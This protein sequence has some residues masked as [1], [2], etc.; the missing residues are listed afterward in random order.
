MQ[1]TLQLG[2][3]FGQAL[4][5]SDGGDPQCGGVNVVG[6]LRQVYRIQRVDHGVVA[7]RSAKQLAGAV[8][9]DFIDIHVGRGSGASLKRVQRK[10]VG[11]AAFR[12]FAGCLEYR[13]TDLGIE[14]A[15]M[16]VHFRRRLL[17]GGDGADQFGVDGLP[18]HREIFQCADRM[19]P[20]IGGGRDWF[21][22]EKVGFRPVH[23]NLLHSHLICC[24]MPSG[25][26]RR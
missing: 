7:L 10:L 21:L 24:S 19:D 3:S 2:A 17:D 13:R 4:Q 25:P 18:R 5:Q 20:V 11:K 26:A 23:G 14:Q 15:Q 8:G 12:Y 9:D 6:R 1:H 22:A 16:Q